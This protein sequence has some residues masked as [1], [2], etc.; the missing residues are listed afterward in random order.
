MSIST[1]PQARARLLIMAKRRVSIHYK[2]RNSF[3]F[4]L[5]IIEPLR[6]KNNSN[7][8]CDVYGSY[9]NTTA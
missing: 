1:I 3:N 2:P 6:Y 4:V 8:F 5:N 9:E 7:T